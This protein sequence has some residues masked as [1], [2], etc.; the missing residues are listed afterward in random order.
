[1]FTERV[2]WGAQAKVAAA[3]LGDVERMAV[4]REAELRRL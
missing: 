4:D 3:L 2:G 1:M